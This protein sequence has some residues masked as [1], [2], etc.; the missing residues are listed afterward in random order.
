MVSIPEINNKKITP[1]SANTAKSE[2]LEKSKKS[3]NHILS[4]M[5]EVIQKPRGEISEFAPRIL[6]IKIA[7]DKI[8]DVIGPGGKIIRKIIADT[9]AE[10]DI[11]DDGTITVAAI[12]INA[13]ESAQQIIKNIVTDAEVGKVYKGKVMRITNFGA[14][15]EILPGKEGLVHISEIS[16]KYI[17]KVSDVLKEGQEI[18]VKCIDIDKQG[19]I[20]LSMKDVPQESEV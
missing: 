19:R 20:G 18:F 6:T 13:A 2:V 4:K 14:F 12:D 11:D 9:G 10:I 7:Q 16:D 15:I 8:K 17:S 1:I 5:E 3:R